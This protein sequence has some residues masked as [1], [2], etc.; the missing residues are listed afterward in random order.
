MRRASASRWSACSATCTRSRVAR[1]W[2]ASWPSAN[3]AMRWN[4]CSRPWSS[5]AANSAAMA[6]RCSNAASTACMRWSRASARATRWR[7]PEALIAEFDLRCARCVCRVRPARTRRNARRNVLVELKP[8]SAPI[9]TALDGE[10]DDVGVRA[11]QEQVRIRADLLDRLVN[12]AGEVAIYRAR[13]EQQLGAFRS[14]MAEMEQTNARLRDQLRRLDIETEAQIIARYQR[15]HESRRRDFR[16]ARARPLL[17]AAAAL[18]RSGRVRGR[19][20]EP[21]GHA[22]R[23][24]PPVRNAA[25]AAVARQLGPAGRPHAHA[26]G[27]VRCAGAAPAPRACA[28]PRSETGKQVQ[29]KLDGAQGE[30]DRNVLERMT[31]PLEHM[32]RNAVAHGLESPEQRRKA[33]QARRRHGPHRGAPRR[34]GSRAG[35]QRRWRAA[36]IAPRSGAAANERG[37][38]ARRRDPVRCATSIR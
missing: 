22:R 16:S 3:S 20:V 17:D 18:A 38:V 26:H 23:P 12:Y 6:C 30:M 7:M 21:A 29:L 25:A 11:P 1:A 14:A 32:L 34:L 35:S 36:S 24:D 5:S 13:L 19:H 37:L 4:R 27:A 8:L 10:E 2:P 31:A 9:D 28:R 33:K 15:E